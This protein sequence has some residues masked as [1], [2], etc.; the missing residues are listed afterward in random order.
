MSAE[1]ERK[2]DRHAGRQ[3]GR[4]TETETKRR[5][6]E[7]TQ[8]AILFLAEVS[9]FVAELTRPQFADRR[10]TQLAYLSLPDLR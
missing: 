7:E 6:D 5:R 10:A 1:R 4:Q 3:A 2:T 8:R 9:Q